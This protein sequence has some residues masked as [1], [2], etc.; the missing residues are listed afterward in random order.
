MFFPNLT[1]EMEKVKYAD[2]IGYLFLVRSK[3]LIK[4]NILKYNKLLFSVPP[5]HYVFLCYEMNDTVLADS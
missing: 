5:D 1:F 2:S 3:T 4:Y